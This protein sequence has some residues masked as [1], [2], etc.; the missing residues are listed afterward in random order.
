MEQLDNALPE[1]SDTTDAAV[2]PSKRKA[3]GLVLGIVVVVGA[4]GGGAYVAYSQYDQ[5]ARTA[6]S[7]T[8]WGDDEGEEEDAPPEFGSF[9]EIQNMIVNPAGTEGRRF[10]MVHIGLES[11]DSDVQAEFE[12]K[13]I[14]I[15]D[16]VLNLLGQRSVDELAD[17]SQREALKEDLREAV[18]QVLVG[19]VNRLYFTQYVLQ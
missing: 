6:A 13:E 4:L 7:L 19:E 8:V 18:N 2:A 12:Q 17:V 10:L 3:L 16:V 14:V 9:F 15:R 1:T 11:L 5:I